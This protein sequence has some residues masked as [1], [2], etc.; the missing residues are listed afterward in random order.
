MR[1]RNAEF[2]MQNSEFRMAQSAVDGGEEGGSLGIEDGEFLGDEGRGWE[3]GAEG[4]VGEIDQ[5]GDERLINSASDLLFGRQVP[6]IER[7]GE[8]LELG[9]ELG[10][11]EIMPAGGREHIAGEFDGLEHVGATEEQTV[12][13][14]GVARSGPIGE[15]GCGEDWRSV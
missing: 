7:V 5:F 12:E 11:G 10:A 8:L 14:S 13:Q 3:W 15:D 6:V 1:S 9:G 2:R 4:L